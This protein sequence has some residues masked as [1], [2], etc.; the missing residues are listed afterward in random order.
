M[1]VR[2]TAL[3]GV[4]VVEPNVIRD[5]R[6]FFVETWHAER[7]A[8]AGI[9]STFVQDNHSRS[10]RHTLRGLH[11]QEEQ[12]QA[13][14]VR[15][16]EGEIFD[17]VVDVRPGSATFGRWVGVSLSD[18]NFLQLYVPEGFA[19]GFCVTSEVAQVEYK[20]S[21]FYYPA[22]E[23]GLI[24]NDP[25]IGIEWPVATPLLSDRDRRHPTLAQAFGRGAA[26]A[27][28]A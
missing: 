4:L 11:W 1:R 5:P 28:Q 26:Q 21:N 15:V 2:E 19:H 12:P 27:R 25:D 13:K 22:G 18:E 8:A 9:A 20:C 7:Y 24:W 3:E 6:G 23:R 17:V 10:G 14:L 16:I